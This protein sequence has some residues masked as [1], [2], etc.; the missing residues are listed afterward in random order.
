MKIH[1]TILS[2]PEL[3]TLSKKE[4]RT[5][6]AEHRYL[7]FKHWQVWAAFMIPFFIIIFSY[8]LAIAVLPKY[9]PFCMDLFSHDPIRY[10]STSVFICFPGLGTIG[11]IV[12][13]EIY[14]SQLRKYLKISD[15]HTALT[16]AKHS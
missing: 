5:K 8:Y 7:P 11:F 9:I 10:V 2:I 13:S 1:W 15:N 3:K 4:A 12:W 14:I 16:D 6:F